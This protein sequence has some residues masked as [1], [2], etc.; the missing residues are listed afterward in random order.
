ML[1]V[2]LLRFEVVP[3]VKLL[4]GVTLQRFIPSSSPGAGR[5][6]SRRFIKK[7]AAR[8]VQGVGSSCPFPLDSES[9]TITM[10]QTL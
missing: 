9:S 1:Q 3:T 7:L 2:M 8:E 10:G 6:S 4:E 5:R